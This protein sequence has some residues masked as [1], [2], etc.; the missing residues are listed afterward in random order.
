VLGAGLLSLGC[1][2]SDHPQYYVDPG[3]GGGSSA[4]GADGSGEATV[5]GDAG[6]ASAGT[7][8]VP[9]GTAGSTGITTGA[10]GTLDASAVYERASAN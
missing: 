6:E 8:G 10:S 3:T 9:V 5:M 2:A 7:A 1:G 4:G